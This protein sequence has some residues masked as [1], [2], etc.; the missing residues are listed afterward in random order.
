M[1]VK[2]DKKL[3]SIE[4]CSILYIE[5]QGDY[6]R[7]HLEDQKLMVHD[8][9]KNFLQSLPPEA[10]LRIHKSFVVNLD[11][12]SYLEGNQ[13]IVGGNAIPVSPAHREELLRRYAPEN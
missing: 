5:G 7:I 13:V 2:A 8:T 11:R 6:I 9:M 1:V 3:Y 12:I 10:F 4:F